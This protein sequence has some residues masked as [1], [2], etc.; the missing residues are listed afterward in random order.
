MIRGERV[1]RRIEEKRAS[2]LIVAALALL[3]APVLVVWAVVA[4]VVIPAGRSALAGMAVVAVPKLS[5]FAV[6]A[7]SVVPHILR[8]LVARMVPP[9]SRV[10]GLAA[11]IMPHILRTMMAFA[12]PPVRIVTGNTVAMLILLLAFGALIT[13]AVVPVRVVAARLGVVIPVLIARTFVTISPPVVCGIT[14][15]MSVPVLIVRA[16]IALPIVP[17]VRLALDLVSVLIVVTAHATGLDGG[18]GRVDDGRQGGENGDDVREKHY[19]R[20]FLDERESSF[21]N[22]YSECL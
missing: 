20:M 12:A 22:I 21:I 8:A 7:T 14:T 4:L 16:V 11:S 17:A 19:E 3:V 6:L 5:D 9:V 13:A 15:L 2:S 1:P 18:G 10:A